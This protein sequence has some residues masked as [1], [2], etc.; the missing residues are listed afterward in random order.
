MPIRWGE[1]EAQKIRAF[2]R[3]VRQLEL[4][5]RRNRRNGW[6]D[7]AVER[8]VDDLPPGMSLGARK[9]TLDQLTRLGYWRRLDADESDDNNSCYYEVIN[10]WLT[11]DEDEA[12]FED[13]EGF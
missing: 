13:M 9:E 1:P 7:N 12:E 11:T 8:D 5:A 10:W 2:D 6:H 3:M 4:E